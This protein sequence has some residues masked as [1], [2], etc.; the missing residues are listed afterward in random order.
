MSLTVTPN[1]RNKIF[2]INA[3]NPLVIGNLTK[4]Y[5]IL[6]TKNLPGFFDKKKYQVSKT[7]Y[8]LNEL[9]YY[10]LMRPY[11]DNRLHFVLIPGAQGSPKIPNYAF[12][13]EKVEAQLEMRTKIAVNDPDFIQVNQET[14]TVL[15]SEMFEKYKGGFTKEGNTILDFIN[16]YRKEGHAIPNAY[17]LG[18]Y[19]YNSRINK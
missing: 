16:K 11:K 4:R 3:Y 5:L 8:T 2:F 15:V 12:R 13:P 6:S 7:Y 14:K 9:E 19:E 10:C 18:Y 1:N 17:T